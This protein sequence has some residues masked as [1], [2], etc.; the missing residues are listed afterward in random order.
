MGRPTKYLE[1]C[2]SI[3]MAT[4][5]IGFNWHWVYV[6]RQIQEAPLLNQV[7]TEWSAPEYL[8]AMNTIYGF[9]REMNVDKNDEL[10]FA[11][12][13][14]GQQVRMEPR[15]KKIDHARRRIVQ[16][17]R[18]IQLFYQKG[19][20]NAE[21]YQG[22]VPGQYHVEFVFRLVEPLYFVE[23]FRRLGKYANTTDIMLN[24]ES[25]TIFDFFRTMYRL[26]P[27][28]HDFDQVR[29]EEQLQK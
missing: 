19:F 28:L 6:F 15:G 10:Q 18:K 14:L 26:K 13:F 8:D 11:Y 12:A 25:T 22:H 7:L 27:P 20:L 23:R 24:A 21:R 4:I 5:T 3:A 1:T 2:L 29:V 16:F 9:A 17:L